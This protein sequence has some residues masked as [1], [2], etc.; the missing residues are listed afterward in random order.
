MVMPRAGRGKV[1]C[2]LIVALLGGVVY[3]GADVAEV[4]FRFY[5]F[6]DAIDQDI[7]YGTTRTDDEIKRHLVAVADSLG[8][9]EEASRRL[10]INRT[11]NRLVIKTAYT[12]HVD[13]PFYKRDILFAPR[14]ESRF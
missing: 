3:F 7:N 6:R 14:A 12:E 1:G 13:V 4:Y 11:A 2:L 10:E 8:L 5:R 9:P